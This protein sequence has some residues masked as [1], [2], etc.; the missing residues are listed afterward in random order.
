MEIGDK[1]FFYVLRVVLTALC[2]G[3]TLYILLRDDT[4]GHRTALKMGLMTMLITILGCAFIIMTPSQV[5]HVSLTAYMMLIVM[6]IMFCLINTGP[7]LTERLFIYI[8]YVALFMLMVGFS[9]FISSLLFPSYL[10]FARLILRMFLSIIFI[11]MLKVF[12]KDRIY[13]LTEGLRIHGLEITMFSWI[14]GLGILAYVIFSSFFIDD[15]VLNLLVLLFLT[16]MLVSIFLIAIRIVHLTSQEIEMEKA[17]GRGRLLE[18]ELEAEKAFVERAKAVRHDQRHHDR[19]V[20][21]YLERGDVD[22]AKEYLGAH[23]RSILEDGLESW[24]SNPLLDA[25][26]RLASRNCRRN[27]IE[28]SVDVR[29]AAET[30]INDI[31]F[32]SVVGNLLENAIE[33]AV[34]SSKP[35]VAIAIKLSNGRLLIEIRNTFSPPLF[36]RS[37]RLES[38]KK[39]GGIGLDSVHMILERNGG[40]LQQEVDDCM[41]VSRIII[42]VKD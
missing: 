33:A 3:V 2:H 28:F 37:D 17:I 5:S 35:Q 12:L 24:C 31:D 19:V 30:A 13:Q 29:I 25:L 1:Q 10:D 4:G 36:W 22:S 9:S 38:T 34:K 7:S 11:I 26:L 41:F 39:G 18:S 16:S 14:L 42:P 6:G 15:P 20:L 32:V 8:M 40:L 23:E 27:R 21:E